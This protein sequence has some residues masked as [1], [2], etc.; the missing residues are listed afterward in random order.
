M[1]NAVRHNELAID[2]TFDKA[3]LQQDHRIRV[4]ALNVATQLPRQPPHA[5]GARGL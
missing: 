5:D 4:D 3:P 1:N 2:C